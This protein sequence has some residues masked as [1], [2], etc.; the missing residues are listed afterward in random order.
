LFGSLLL[1][2]LMIATVTSVTIKSAAT[3]ATIHLLLWVRR[4]FAC[5]FLAELIAFPYLFVNS[6]S[7]LLLRQI[8]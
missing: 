3:P 5:I 1:G 6:K 4:L 8:Q 2:D 7:L